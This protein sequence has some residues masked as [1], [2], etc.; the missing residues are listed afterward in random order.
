MRELARK[1]VPQGPCASEALTPSLSATLRSAAAGAPLAESDRADFEPRFG[2]SLAHVR[3]HTDPISRTLTNS[4]GAEGFT[5]G[6]DVYFAKPPERGVLAHELAHAAQDNPPEVLHLQ[7]AYDAKAAAKKINAALTAKTVDK[8]ALLAAL[9][10]HARDAAHAASLKSEYKTAF[11]KELEADLKAKL[12]VDTLS[13]ALFLLH[14]PLPETRRYSDVTI[15]K[16]GT[17]EHKAKAGGGTISVR[18]GVDFTLAKDKT[19]KFT[20]A[21]SVA[22]SGTGFADTHIVQ[23]L[24][25]EIIATTGGKAKHVPRSGLGSTGGKM[26][27]TTN[28]KNP[29]MVIDA[30]AASPFYEEGSSSARTA[31]GL[32]IFDRPFEFKHVIEEEF[33]KGATQVVERDHFDTFLIQ[34]EKPVYHVVIVVEWVYTSKTAFTRKTDVKSGTAVTALPAA[35]KKQLVK[36]H[37]K[38]EYIR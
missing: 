38:Y 21:F 11:G 36:Q 6:S 8:K 17:E 25:A 30:H 31:S 24:W 14:G 5:R 29:Q 26:D 3:V 2:V 33:D 37:P 22:Y 28:I 4:L 19:Q 35:V 9:A 1:P 18:K 34:K 27:L 12:K 15:D 20:D 16:A 7:P 32:T 10:V 23:T 13:R